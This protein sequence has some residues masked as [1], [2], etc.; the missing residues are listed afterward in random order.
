MI[1][2][3]VAAM[4]AAMLGSVGTPRART[5][6]TAPPILRDNVAHKEAAE[7][8]RA[9]KAHKRTIAAANSQANYHPIARAAAAASADTLVKPKRVR[10]PAATKA[11]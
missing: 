4:G 11:A 9:R 5:G 8:E 1:V 6:Y 2:N 10:K 7:R 3:A